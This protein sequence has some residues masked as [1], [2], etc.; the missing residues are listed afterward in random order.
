MW[1]G[2][3]DTALVFAVEVVADLVGLDQDGRGF[4][5]SLSV[6]V[7]DDLVVNE[8]TGEGKAELL[9][10]A[11]VQRV[12]Q[13]GFQAAGTCIDS[14]GEEVGRRCVGGL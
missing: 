9:A 14:V 7:F 3:F 11:Y 5:D 4:D 1:V 2:H 12:V 10:F 13:H 8:R 6:V